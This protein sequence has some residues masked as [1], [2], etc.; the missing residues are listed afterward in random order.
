MERQLELSLQPLQSRLSQVLFAD[1]S[2]DNL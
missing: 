2:D 1:G